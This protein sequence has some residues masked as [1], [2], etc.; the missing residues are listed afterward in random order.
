MTAL[1]SGVAPNYAANKKLN[2]LVQKNATVAKA[3]VQPVAAK[4]EP[5]KFPRVAS[6]Q[7]EEFGFWDLPKRF[8]SQGFGKLPNR[9]GCSRATR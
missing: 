9:F 6:K 7:V 5:A 3:A 8:E 4:K 2:G 1:K